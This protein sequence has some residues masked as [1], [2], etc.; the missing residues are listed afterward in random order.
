VP[1]LQT[2]SSSSAL[3]FPALPPPLTERTH[4]MAPVTIGGRGEL[5]AEP[6]S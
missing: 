4:G 6:G 1:W 3:P 5:R 2:G